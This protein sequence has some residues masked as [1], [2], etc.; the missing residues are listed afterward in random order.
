MSET[1]IDYVSTTYN[2]L[3]R[4]MDGHPYTA[5][6]MHPETVTAVNLAT[7]PYDYNTHTMPPSLLGMALIVD[8]S[9]EPGQFRFEYEVAAM[10]REG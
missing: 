6:R 3:S 4:A 5:V 2:A 10:L 1:M 9:V 7:A 8:D